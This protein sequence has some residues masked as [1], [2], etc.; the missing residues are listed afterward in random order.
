MSCN[1]KFILFL[2]TICAIIITFTSPRAGEAISCNYYNDANGILMTPVRC[3]VQYKGGGIV[4]DRHRNMIF[5]ELPNQNNIILK[6]GS[7]FAI[8]NG[9]YQL[10]SSPVRVIKGHAMAPILFMNKFIQTAITRINPDSKNIGYTAFDIDI[11]GDNFNPGAKVK[12]GGYNLN[13]VRVESTS[14][15]TATVP[16]G[17]PV[18][19]YSVTVTNTDGSSGIMDNCFTVIDTS[20]TIYRID[21][22]EKDEDYDTFTMTVFGANFSSGTEVSIGGSYKLNNIKI[23]STTRLTGEV[24]T[25]IPAGIYDVTVTGSDGWS[26]TLDDSFRVIGEE[27]EIR[28]VSPGRAS[29]GN[30]ITIEGSN[31]RK[32]ITVEIGSHE[33]SDIKRES[34]TKITGKIPSGISNGTYDI[35]V[36]NEDETTDTK[37][38]CLE[39]R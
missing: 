20:P 24:P 27:P 16:E 15:I 7:N 38:N 10:M 17:I 11:T 6:P 13:N 5:I 25:G 28:N 39:V 32:N 3:L 14:R 12:I 33:L 18:G 30:T 34:D 37:Q 31:F 21:P 35:T 22:N 4:W 2:A 26:E 23:H 1:R 9:E 29:T 8:V 19:T 36:T